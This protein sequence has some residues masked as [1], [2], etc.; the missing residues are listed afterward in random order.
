M[1]RVENL[2]VEG[3][4][5]YPWDNP[6]E[7]NKFNNMI[8]E[9]MRQR[10]YI[11]TTFPTNFIE[12]RFLSMS[13]VLNF[14]RMDIKIPFFTKI[15]MFLRLE[16][17]Q[18]I[19]ETKLGNIR[20]DLPFNIIVYMNSHTLNNQKGFLLNIRSEPV[21]LFQMRQLR[22]R[23]NLDDF[24]YSNIIETNKQFINE[25]MYGTGGVIIEKPKV[26]AEI[27]HTPFIEVLK[28]LGFDKIADLLK[29]GNLKLERGDIEDGLTDL[30][31]AL[32]LFIEEM[33]KKINQEPATNFPSNLDILKKYEYVDA[34]LYSVIRDTLYEWMYRYISD[35]PVH[36]REKININDAKLFFSMSEVLM[37]YLIEKVVYRR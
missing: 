33:V 16:N 20:E 21:L 15:A 24:R 8:S 19:Y 11:S 7:Y 17:S 25:I 36:K 18:K 28:N 29:Q 32:Q 31:G 5:F 2:I 22:Y 23:P 1:T 14:G 3:K 12:D 37:N 13:F 35:K 10:L 9:F 26:I 30:R 34:H 27:I 4:C 6:Q